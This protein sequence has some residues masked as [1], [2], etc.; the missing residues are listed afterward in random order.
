MP[1][2]DGVVP[3]PLLTPI[4]DRDHYVEVIHRLTREAGPVDNDW[5]H[6]LTSEAVPHLA[7]HVLDVFTLCRT[8][9]DLFGTVTIDPHLEAFRGVGGYDEP[10]HQAG[11]LTTVV[12]QESRL[13]LAGRSRS[14]QD[15]FGALD[16]PAQSVT[17]TILE[18]LALEAELLVLEYNDLVGA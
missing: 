1:G 13:A 7:E 10:L 15:F 9:P 2:D 8:T 18:R 4:S 14:V 12:L 3:L 16:G 6:L 11:V 5:S 17:L